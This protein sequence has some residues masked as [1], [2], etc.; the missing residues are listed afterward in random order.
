[1]G[2]RKLLK[3]YMSHIGAV[4]GS[5]LV[6]LAALTQALSRRELG[7]LRT[8][9]AELKREGYTDGEPQ[10]YDPVVRSLIETGEISLQDIARAEKFEDVSDTPANPDDFRTTLLDAAQRMRLQAGTSNKP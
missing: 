3:D 10:N 1:M 4:L 5:D 9:A 2:Y 7:E 6:E 8:I